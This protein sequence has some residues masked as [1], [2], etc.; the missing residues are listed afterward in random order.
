MPKNPAH[1]RPD[2]TAGL[3]LRP[4]EHYEKCAECR[5]VYRT[6]RRTRFR[7]AY[8]HALAYAVETPEGEPGRRRVLEGDSTG[9]VY[10]TLDRRR[11]DGEE[12]PAYGEDYV[13]FL[14]G[15]PE[16]EGQPSSAAAPR[17]SRRASTP[18]GV[19]APPSEAR[20]RARRDATRGP[21]PRGG[22]LRRLW[23]GSLGENVRRG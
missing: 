1:T 2:T 11:G 6:K 23:H 22:L 7:C 16:L 8:C 5:G 9:R 17:S 15:E 10:R 18:P 14:E 20:A 3:P 13:M 19:A 21:A 12:T 4:G